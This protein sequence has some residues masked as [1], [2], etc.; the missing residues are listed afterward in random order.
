MLPKLCLKCLP[1]LVSPFSSSRFQVQSTLCIYASTHLDSSSVV[2]RPW[3]INL[4]RHRVVAPLAPGVAAHD[5]P[6]CHSPT[7]DDAKTLYGFIP[8]VRARRVE[9][10]GIGRQ[11]LREGAL[12][13]AYQPEDRSSHLFCLPVVS[14]VSDLPVVGA[15]S[16]SVPPSGAV[17]SLSIIRDCGAGVAEPTPCCWY[18]LLRASSSSTAPATSWPPAS[19]MGARAIHTRSQPDFMRGSLTRTASLMRRLA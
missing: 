5:A 3:S 16:V 15:L 6:E 14:S 10:T 12:V 17:I 11:G 8:V 7:L 1:R 19:T 4:L 2:C 13:E 9:A 18:S